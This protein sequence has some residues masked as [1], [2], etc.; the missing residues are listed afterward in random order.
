MSEKNT[1]KGKNIVISLGEGFVLGSGV[2]ALLWATTAY[3]PDLATPSP[4][5]LPFYTAE[6]VHYD[7]LA[8][9]SIS[10]IATIYGIVKKDYGLVVK[11]IGMALGNV[12]ISQFQ[13]IP[14]VPEFKA[15]AVAMVPVGRVYID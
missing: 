9:L 8:A 13:A 11:G 2:D 3:A 1:V 5:K 6:G 15:E 12:V 7:D 4:L 14:R 10:A